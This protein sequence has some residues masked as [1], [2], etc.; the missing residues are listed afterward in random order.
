MTQAVRD[1]GQTVVRSW[2]RWERSKN[3][4]RI[5]T[6]YSDALHFASD[7]PYILVTIDVHL[8]YRETL[9]RAFYVFVVQ[10]AA[11][12]ERRQSGSAEAKADGLQTREQLRCCRAEE[13]F[14]CSPHKSRAIR[15]G[16][17][18]LTYTSKMWCEP[19]IEIIIAPLQRRTW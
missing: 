9:V 4:G 19:L 17:S 10:C 16:C 14:C 8:E 2:P 13:S 18:G 7:Q 5:R 1:I 12:V 3:L 11:A 6:H 15:L